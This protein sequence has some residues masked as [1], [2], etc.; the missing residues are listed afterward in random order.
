[1][2]GITSTL[3]RTP[4]QYQ[5]FHLWTVERNGETAGALLITSPHNLVIAEPLDS[6]ALTFAAS[7]LA[8]AGHRFPG[9][10]GGVPEVDVFADAWL[11]EA[12][13]ENRVRMRQGIYAASVVREPSGVAGSM[14]FA[15]TSDRA[16]LL[17]WLRRFEAE[18]LPHDAPHR[19]L[20][21]LVDRRTAAGGFALWDVDNQTL[22]L[23]GSGGATP[24]GVR[25]GPV[26]TPPE[27]RRRGY[28]GALVAALTQHLLAGGLDYCF[29]YTDLS[30][31]TSN[32]VYKSVGYELVCESVDYEF[33]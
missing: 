27:F 30:N 6:E 4:E 5:E 25:I 21:L 23:A 19:E 33:D 24:H 8:R 22:S 17:D 18:A 15:E 7:E 28:A 32:N 13:A 20:E 12:G 14:R 3:T 10:V 29:L 9:V 26:Y 16:L 1:M 11:S 31:A 2:Y